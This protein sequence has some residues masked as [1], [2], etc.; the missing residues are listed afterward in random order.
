MTDDVRGN[1]HDSSSRPSPNH[2]HHD[3]LLIARFAAGD[4]YPTE[5]NDAHSLVEACS[6]CAALA[7]EIRLLMGVTAALPAPRRD[8]DFRISAEQAQTM[9]GTLLDRLLRRLAAPSLAPLRPVA[10]VALSLGIVLAVAG[11]ALPADT[12]SGMQSSGDYLLGR[13]A[14][15]SPAAEYFEPDSVPAPAYGENGVR[16]NG[17][18]GAPDAPDEVDTRRLDLGESTDVAAL[19]AAESGT[20]RVLLIYGGVTLAL[21]SFGLLLLAIIAR[22]REGDPL[23]R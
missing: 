20:M 2:G 7:D 21:L 22:R 18:A 23:I 13:A 1:V 8:R 19:Q 16:G 17:A 11:A 3:R 15:P 9:R 12:D 10:G 14:M 4:A 6:H 5:L